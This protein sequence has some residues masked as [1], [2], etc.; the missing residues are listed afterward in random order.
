VVKHFSWSPDARGKRRIHKK[1]RYSEIKACRPWLDA[2]V[3]LI[4]PQAVV[5]LG[6][7]AAQAIF[8]RQFRVTRE[9]GRIMDSPIATNT[10]ATLHP[11]AIL[12]APDQQSRQSMRRAL[13]GDL[14]KIARVLT[15]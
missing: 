11:S 4:R 7:T 12:R 1:P 2:E 15:R 14:K 3:D 13:T 9:R 8:G 10:M 6:A 5:C